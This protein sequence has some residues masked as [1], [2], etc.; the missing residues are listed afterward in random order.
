M[1]TCELLSLDQRSSCIFYALPCTR[2]SVTAFADINQIFARRK[3][4]KMSLSKKMF[5][6]ISPVNF[7]DNQCLLFLCCAHLIQCLRSANI[8]SQLTTN[9]TIITQLLS[10]HTTWCRMAV[11]LM[12]VLFE[13][14]RETIFDLKSWK[15]KHH[16][17]IVFNVLTKWH[18][19]HYLHLAR[20]AFHSDA[21]QWYHSLQDIF[22]CPHF[23]DPAFKNETT[24]LW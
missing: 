15:G 21:N 24:N 7:T 2:F 14:H 17:V 1:C 23:S 8:P 9:V 6:D 5:R 18:Q 3:T 4:I 16:A 22:F 10:L 19:E 11:H 20:T 12:S 13:S